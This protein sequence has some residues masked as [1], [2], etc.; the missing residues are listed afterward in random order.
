MLCGGSEC[1]V[2]ELG[3]KPDI[4]SS[5]IQGC[6]RAFET[7]P[8]LADD[9]GRILELFGICLL[10]QVLVPESPTEIRDVPYAISLCDFDVLGFRQYLLIKCVRD[11]LPKSMANLPAF[12]DFFDVQ[13]EISYRFLSHLNVPSELLL[14]YSS[15][16]TLP[17]SSTR[18][19]IH[20]TPT[21]S[22]PPYRYCD[23]TRPRSLL[24]LALS[25]SRI[26]FGAPLFMP[27]KTMQST[28]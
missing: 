27:R 7:H 16:L 18:M 24:V 8:E 15:W 10:G 21:A 9:G 20:S 2:P 14:H 19:V 3:A 1:D 12:K 13:V 25:S 28:G 26:R 6:E 11:N 4:N 5:P 22:Q 23:A 17:S